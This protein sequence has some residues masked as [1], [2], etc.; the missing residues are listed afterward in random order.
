MADGDVSS[1][2]K[3]NELKH[4][5]AGSVNL[6]RHEAQC[7][8]CCHPH[9][10][11]IEEVF[12]DWGSVGSVAL[13]CKVDR[14]AIYRHAHAFGLFSLRKRN[15]VRVLEKIL[16]RGE[17]T[18]LNGSTILSAFKLYVKVNHEEKGDEQPQTESQGGE[19][20][21]Q[22]TETTSVQ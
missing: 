5:P 16:E 20:E 12:V 14:Y 10:R 21:S 18:Q 4:Q 9:R 19:K 8:I 17:D 6:G 3:E 2:V 22:I 11:Y 7:S 1:V 15:V 13:L